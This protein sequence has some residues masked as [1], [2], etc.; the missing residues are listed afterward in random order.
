MMFAPIE[1]L[2][3]KLLSIEKKTEQN[4]LLQKDAAALQQ[5][6]HLFHTNTFIPLTSWSISPR[7]VLH[8][9]NDICI[10]NRKSIVEFGAGFSTLCIAALLK[11]RGEKTTFYSIENSEVWIQQLTQQL[12]QLGLLDYVTFI[13]APITTV[14]DEISLNEQNKWYDTHILT[15]ILLEQ[16]EYVDLIIVDGPFGGTTPYARYSALPFLYEKLASSYAVF[17]DDTTRAEE[18]HILNTWHEK[19]SGK[20]IRKDR[21]ALLTDTFDFDTS[22]YGN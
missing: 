20:L 19:L 12:Q 21:Y 11:Q 22:P 15:P 18:K 5:L 7:E 10:H 16:L 2:K 4:A 13:Y 3:K 8:I 14:P 6:Y 17:L 9:C 1:K